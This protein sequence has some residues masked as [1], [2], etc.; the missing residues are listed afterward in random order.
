MKRGS[1]MHKM[2][3][4]LVI[5]FGFAFLFILTGC[6][7]VVTPKEVF[8]VTFYD[9]QNQVIST[10]DVKEGED[11]TAPDEPLREGYTFLEWSVTFTNVVSNLDVYPIYEEIVQTYTVRFRDHNGFILHIENIEEGQNATPPQDPSREGYIFI[12]WNASYENIVADIDI[13]AQYEVILNTYTVIFFDDEDNIINT[14][15]VEEGSAAVAPTIPTKEGYRFIGWSAGFSYVL[16]D[17]EIR[18]IFELIITTERTNYAS[19]VEE[20]QYQ[21]MGS[22]SGLVDKIDAENDLV[23]SIPNIIYGGFRNANQM[24]LYDA[25]N[26]RSRNAYGYEVAV[27]ANGIVIDKATLVDL[28]LGGF[29]LSGHS[30]TA[31][32]LREN[33]N[34]GDI[35]MYQASASK[36]DIYRNASVSNV[37]GLGIY[38]QMVQE[39]T[40]RA[41]YDELR[42]LD[43]QEIITKINQ[44]ISN[45][46]SLVLSYQASLWTQTRGVLLDVEF[47][48]VEVAPVTVKSFWH[49][50]L[51]AGSFSENNLQAVQSF[52]DELADTGYNRVY[53]NTNFNGSSIYQS[54]ILT[55]RLTNNHTYTG[56]K[57]YLEAFISEA[58]MRNIEV[59]AWTNTLIAGDG[60]FP[61]SYDQKGWLQVGF[62]GDKSFNG[63]YFLDISNPEVQVFLRD[64][65]YELS[66]SYN[67]DGI[68]YDFIRYPGGNMHSYSGTITNTSGLR[69]S[70]YTDSMISSFMEEYQLSGDLKTLLL[71]SNTIRTNW[72]QFKRSMLTD[73]VEMISNTIRSGNPNTRISAAVMPSISTARNTYL[74]DWD[75]WIENG[76][77]DELD[78]MI[79]SGSNDYVR[80]TLVNMYQVVNNRASIIAGIFPEGDGGQSGLN[81]EQIQI[82]NDTYVAG[83]SKFSGRTIYNNALLANSFKM[84]YREYTAL[85]SRSSLEMVY[86]YVCDLLDK[87]ENF[88]QFADLDTD[89]QDFI[90]RLTE[91]FDDLS[92]ECIL[93]VQEMLEEIA[94]FIEDISH[95]VVQER[96]QKQ[97]NYMQSLLAA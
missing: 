11:A 88:Y 51:R 67:L 55:Q 27:D 17:L 2:T 22:L 70:G 43:Y 95:S 41:Y 85:P 53:L 71:E 69:D 37:I 46:N 8:T 40:S 30:G 56:Y 29:I 64:V 5:L 47:L 24:I 21:Q 19:F 1:I 82:I 16:S 42:P 65:F 90:V 23:F 33:I 91:F 45:F 89:Y 61:T 59:Y 14:Q 48:L 87:V 39:N 49:Y 81:A 6:D 86:A 34:I 52:L 26:I 72:L 80:N 60:S 4:F 96:L 66:S 74:Q 79:Y 13:Y 76:W 78:P 35:A 31:T 93:D 94:D 38:I 18:A 97:N 77:I 32:Y 28:P 54:S 9:Y 15:E 50:P 58:H 63:M 73:T 68:E 12:G 84:L 44:A 36:V 10:Q 3:K 20:L 7:E 57:D 92:H 25:S 83:W 75:T 62:D